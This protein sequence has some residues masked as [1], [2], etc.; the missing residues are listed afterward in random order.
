[1]KKQPAPTDLERLL[2]PLPAQIRA[3]AWAARALVLEAVPTA[4]ERVRLGWSLLGFDAPRYF[5]CV[6]PQPDRVRIGFEHGVLLDDPAALLEGDG[7]QMRWVTVRDAAD[8][9]VPALG[10]L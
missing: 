4:T 7:T 3:L 9:E 1:M 10:A 6:A 5:A 2:A 8:L